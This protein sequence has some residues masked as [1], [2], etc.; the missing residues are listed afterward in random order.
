M[1][2]TLNTRE[3]IINMSI[4]ASMLS[5]SPVFFTLSGTA[6]TT[7]ALYRML[8]GIF[9][10][11]IITFIRK[12]KLWKGPKQAKAAFIAAFFF[13]IDLSVWHKCIALLGPGVA[14]LFGNLM[15][16]VLAAYGVFFLKEKLTFRIKLSIPLALLGLAM[17]I[18]FEWQ[19]LAE[20]VKEGIF[21]G[22]LTAFFF[23]LFMVFL[24]ISQKM[25]D[26]LEPN[27]NIA[28][29]SFF[30]AIVMVV[31]VGYMGDPFIVTGVVP[32]ASLLGYGVFSQ[33]LGHVFISKGLAGTAPSLAGLLHLI[34]PALA[35]VW[36]ILLFSKPIIFLE[37]FG[38]VITLT[39]VYIGS[40]K[41]SKE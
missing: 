10:L 41:S 18:G 23:G 8:V 2:N 7:A 27:A 28:N 20:N 16:F 31:I 22:I 35:Y 1:T 38:F 32:L 30:T 12:E 4:G 9:F 19:G 25:E 11:S 6:P 3:G 34:Q 40:Q 26:A 21:Y 13:A 5:F 36:D 15:V 37:F 39:A 24:R 29:I 14:T 33:V 17:I